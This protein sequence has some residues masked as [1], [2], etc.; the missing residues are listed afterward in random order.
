MFPRVYS[1]LANH[2]S[3]KVYLKYRSLFYHIKIEVSVV[4]PYLVNGELWTPRKKIKKKKD[5]L[6]SLLVFIH[7]WVGADRKCLKWDAQ[8][9][10]YL[11]VTGKR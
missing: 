8:C 4:Q 9:S 5:A 7:K 2:L 6:A 3:C 11:Q 10:G 1:V